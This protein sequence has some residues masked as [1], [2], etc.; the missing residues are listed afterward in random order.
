MRLNPGWV[1]VLILMEVFFLWAR[2]REKW[3]RRGLRNNRRWGIKNRLLCF[4]WSRS[5]YKSWRKIK[6]K[7]TIT[8]SLF[9]YLSCDEFLGLWDCAVRSQKRFVFW[10]FLEDENQFRFVTGVH[11]PTT[12]QKQKSTDDELDSFYTTTGVERWRIMKGVMLN[13]HFCSRS[14]NL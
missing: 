7:L 4:W 12:P 3:T 8:A 6:L 2:V 9:G 1:E 10:R 11:K 5:N 13:L 14:R